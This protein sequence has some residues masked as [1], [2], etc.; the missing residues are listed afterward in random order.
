M[1]FTWPAF[2]CWWLISAEGLGLLGDAKSNAV[3][4]AILNMISKGGFTLAMLKMG[5]D[6]R[7]RW[8]DTSGQQRQSS[9]I[10]DQLQSY[11]RNESQGSHGSPELKPG[12]CMIK[13]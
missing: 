6:H 5:A 8:P 4:F 9:W 3:G 10:V 12:S 13:S 11:E 2:P 1:W 7:V